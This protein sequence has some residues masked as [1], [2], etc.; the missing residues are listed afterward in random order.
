MCGLTSRIYTCSSSSTKRPPTEHD[1]DEDEVE[2][3]TQAFNM[4]DTLARLSADTL[5]CDEARVQFNTHL[6]QLASKIRKKEPSG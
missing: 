6:E 3:T 5:E 4:A 1:V 2:Q